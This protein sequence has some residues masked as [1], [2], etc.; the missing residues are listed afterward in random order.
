[1]EAVGDNGAK[2]ARDNGYKP[3]LPSIRSGFSMDALVASL[4]MYDFPS[5]AEANARLWAAIGG[6][7]RAGG[8]GAPTALEAA[9]PSDLWTNPRLI[10]GQTCG[11]PFVT[12]LRDRVTLIATP[13]YS[14]EGCDGASHCSFIVVSARSRGRSLAGFEGAR[15]AL[16][17]RDS[18]SG[19]NLF[20]GLFAPIARGRPMFSQVIVTGSHTASLAAIADGAADIAAIDCVSYA[21]LRRDRPE[22]FDN[23]ATI[24]RTPS[25]PGLPF[26]MNAELGKSLAAAVRVALFA[27]LNDPALAD[28]RETLGLEGATMLSEAEYQ[29]VAE[30]ERGAIALGYP[31]L[32]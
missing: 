24:A 22:L 14:F 9:P 17:S 5:V 7:L 11:Y 30:I 27:A 19:M 31:E 10:F 21:L 16:N 29:K 20:R 26:V 2:L 25:S 3:R 12:A 32:A 15:A 28:A 1:V 8:V 13:I 4:G 23:V 6:Y 18:N